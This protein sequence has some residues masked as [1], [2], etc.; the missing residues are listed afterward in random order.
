MKVWIVVYVGWFACVCVCVW[1]FYNGACRCAHTIMTTIAYQ[2][3]CSAREDRA[4]TGAGY[5][6]VCGSGRVDGVITFPC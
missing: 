3:G 5:R 6:S 4:Q 1:R 2:S